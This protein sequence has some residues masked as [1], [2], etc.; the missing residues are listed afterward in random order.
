MPNRLAHETSPYLLQHARNPVDWYPWGEEALARSRQED[1]PIFLSVGY[2]AC[3][4]CHVME[5]E[6]FEDPAIAALLNREFICIK[7]DREER[8]D[9][10]QV[11]MTAVQ[12]M[13]GRGGWPMSVFLTPQREPFFAGT[14]WPPVPRHG[15]PGFDQVVRAVADAWRNRKEQALQQAADFTQRIRGDADRSHPSQSPPASTV[16]LDAARKLEQSF[17]PTYG[18]FGHAPKFPHPMDLQV[19]LR[20]WH[21]TG[22]TACL[23]MVRITLDRMARG[24]IYDHLGGGFARYS[25]DERWLVPHFEKML[26]D[27][28]LLV[29]CYLDAFTALRH[30]PFAHVVRQ[31]LEYVLGRMTDPQGAFF[32]SEDADS[33]GVEG[34][35]YVWRLE[36]VE[37]VLG[38]ER[39]ERFCY[40]YD[41]SEQ[42][43]FEGQSI[44]NL[45]KTIE[46]CA[47]VRGW[48]AAQLAAD[49]Q[50]DRGL[51]LAQRNTRVPPAKD[52][53]ILVSWNALMIDSMAR[54]GATLG[55]PRF[56]E[57]AA[58]AAHFLLSHVRDRQGRLFH[59]WRQGQVR[60]AGF[61]EDYAS[62]ANALVTLYESSFQEPWIDEA[63]SLVEVMR[64]HF[65]DRDQG[66]FYFTADDHEQLIARQKDFVDSSV[67]SSNGLAATVLIRLGRLCGRQDY[68]SQARATLEA[69][70]NLLEKAPTAAGQLLVALD[71][72]NGPCPELA[73]LGSPHDAAT[74]DVLADL[75]RR[76]IP[77]KVVALRPSS[78]VEDGSYTLDPLFQGRKAGLDPPTVYLCEKF[79]CS[80]P[81]TGT[82][83][84][85]ELWDRLAKTGTGMDGGELAGA[86]PTAS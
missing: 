34:K 41:V 7:V 6:S 12:L 53:K 72:L 71:M 76:Y 5:H 40:V 17:D 63:V 15:M 49:L 48:D 59:A 18:G 9:L 60:I 62:L 84:A 37:S 19:L 20:V 21:R 38:R 30:E 66:G 44:L 51:L 86:E 42:G 2:S 29:G 22:R 31:T 33:E 35:Y 61:L 77:N 25:V 57:A 83:S 14:Y 69:S 73:I 67:P 74:I 26:Y 28:A 27:N 36:E 23:D 50:E 13:T 10:D 32:S 54:A 85:L 39:S 82:K 4:W 52:D 1:K 65:A 45:P 78:E 3:H 64:S 8:P 70:G 79:V 81:I 80:A 75:R 56:L 58:R 68:L 43:N 46:Q 24:G 55:E 47:S 11:Y 16:L